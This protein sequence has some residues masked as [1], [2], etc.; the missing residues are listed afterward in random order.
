MSEE[1]QAAQK[2]TP[3]LTTPSILYDLTSGPKRLNKALVYYC[4]RLKS[5]PKLVVVSLLLVE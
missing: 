1:F 4:E 5:V 3:R 2:L